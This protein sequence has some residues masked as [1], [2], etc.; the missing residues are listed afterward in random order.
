MQI[1][2]AAGVPAPNEMAC[3]KISLDHVIGDMGTSIAQAREVLAKS[4]SILE[5]VHKEVLP[6][7]EVPAT[8][9]GFLNVLGPGTST[10]VSFSCTLM[11]RGSESTFKLILGHGIPRNFATAMSDLPR[12]PNGKA[13]SLK[14]VAQPAA[15]L[16]KTFMAT[17]D[18]IAAEAANRATMGMSESASER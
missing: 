18:R 11:I 1:S 10:M 13:V 17:M 9:D 12:R 5:A 16:A 15:E 14:G 6:H 4:A 8:S 3:D 7:N 2:E